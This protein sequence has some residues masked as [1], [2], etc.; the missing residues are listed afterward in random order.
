MV[1]L[2]PHHL[3]E[4]ISHSREYEGDNLVGPVNLGHVVSE[5]TLLDLHRELIQPALFESLTSTGGFSHFVIL[6]FTFIYLV[7]TFI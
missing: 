7:Y 4:M 2:G 1:Y 6:S 5:K 3:D